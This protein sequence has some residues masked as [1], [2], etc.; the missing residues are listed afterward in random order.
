MSSGISIKIKLD[1]FLQSFLREIYKQPSGLFRF[2]PR[3]DL[4]TKLSAMIRMAP[5]NK[6][7]RLYDLMDVKWIYPPEP[8][9]RVDYGD[10]TFEI[11]IPFMQGKNLDQYNYLPQNSS[12][13][14][15]SHIHQYFKMVFHE[16]IND[17]R[18]LGFQKKEC[19]VMF[20]NKHFIDEDY[21][22]RLMKD[23]TRYCS[24]VTSLKDLRKTKKSPLK[25]VI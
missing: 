21:F 4:S 12:K 5:R 7:T 15:S 16:E 19:V 25:E 22:D 1:P 3:T 10:D 23:Y 2:P 17:L 20:M 9:K 11:E 8:I 18:Y 6:T 24:K 13:I 14:L